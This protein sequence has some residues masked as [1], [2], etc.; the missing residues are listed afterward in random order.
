MINIDNLN[1]QHDTIKLEI[2]FLEQEISKQ[3]SEINVQET[4]MHI[5]KLAGL[6]KIH[7]ME[8]DKFL[9]PRLLSSE[10]NEIQAMTK[11]YIDEMGDLA[12][13]YFQFKNAY[14]VASK[15]NADM[16]NFIRSAKITIELLKTR[17]LKEDKELYQIIKERAL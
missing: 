15:I 10:D 17:I 12:N 16:D 9:Y 7:L 11:L 2:E 6:L 5:S 8:E 4:A 3:S 13:H 1:R 14:N